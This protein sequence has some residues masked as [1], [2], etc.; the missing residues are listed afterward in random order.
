MN[1]NTTTLTRQPSGIVGVIALTALALSACA[2]ADSTG[3]SIGV[4]AQALTAPPG[5]TGF[6]DIHEDGV[7]R[8][9][10]LVGAR[11]WVEAQ[12]KLTTASPGQAA[13]SGGSRSGFL[14]SDYPSADDGTFEVLLTADSWNGNAG[15]VSDHR[16]SVSG[17]ADR[18]GPEHPF[19]IDKQQLTTVPCPHWLRAA[20]D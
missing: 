10:S 2:A 17:A 16:A 20:P 3:E 15:G 14:I 18:D 19:P 12:G 4:S 9:W 1:T 13:K 11:R 5:S 8:G 6:S 7:L